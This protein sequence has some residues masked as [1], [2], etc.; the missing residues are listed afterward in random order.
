MLL[1][2]NAFIN[3]T[4]VAHCGR[5]VVPSS[6]L[7]AKGVN[8]ESESG[9]AA[10]DIKGEVKEHLFGKCVRRT[11]NQGPVCRWS[12]PLLVSQPITVALSQ[13]C[14]GERLPVKQTPGSEV[15]N[16]TIQVNEFTVLQILFESAGMC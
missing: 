3:L 12:A 8:T 6:C 16:K 13:M 10:N 7:I 14:A 2:L 5:Q 15:H 9:N 4:A 1:I 11:C